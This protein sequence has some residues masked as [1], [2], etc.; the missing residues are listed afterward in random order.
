MSVGTVAALYRRARYC[1]VIPP[2]TACTP[3]AP[4]ANICTL[5]STLPTH[6]VTATIS[7]PDAV[8]SHVIISRAGT[9]L[10]QIHNYS[11]VK[12][13]VSSHVGLSA[14]HAITIRGH[15]QEVGDAMI[16]IGHWIAK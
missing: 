9:G 16:A 13:N 2:T 5:S 15:P 3:H 12:V 6:R 1:T 8:A 7:I 14:S 11:H 4:S 10:H